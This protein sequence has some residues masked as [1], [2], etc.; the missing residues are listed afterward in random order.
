MTDISLTSNPLKAMLVLN[1]WNRGHLF[2]FWKLIVCE[3]TIRKGIFSIHVLKTHQ[4]K[5][6]SHFIYA[7]IVIQTFSNLLSCKFNFFNSQVG[8]QKIS[9]STCISYLKQGMNSLNDDMLNTKKLSFKNYWWWSKLMNLLGY[10]IKYIPSVPLFA[11]S[12]K[13]IL[14][15]FFY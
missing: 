3:N 12:C 4:H 10:C 2:F 11:V 14:L 15:Y 8:H 7:Y 5:P 1:H 6:Q 9:I 13:G